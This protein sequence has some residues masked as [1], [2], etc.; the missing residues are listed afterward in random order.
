MSGIS[1]R[2]FTAR[3]SYAQITESPQN[4]LGYEVLYVK[5]R[6]LNGYATYLILLEGPSILP[7]QAHQNSA[8]PRMQTLNVICFTRET[9]V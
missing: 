3:L 8:Q 1:I 5:A 9:C 6:S 7:I 4:Q 2:V